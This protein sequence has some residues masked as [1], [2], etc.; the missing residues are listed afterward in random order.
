VNS[1][2]DQGILVWMRFHRGH[3]NDGRPKRQT[4]CYGARSLI[5][6]KKAASEGLGGR[7]TAQLFRPGLVAILG[8]PARPQIY[9]RTAPERLHEMFL[10]V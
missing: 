9:L 8:V 10:A 2:H 5:W 4:L 6:A 3:H 7:Q 1:S